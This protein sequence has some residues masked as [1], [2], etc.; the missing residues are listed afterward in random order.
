MRPE[1]PAE[2]VVEK[3]V[4][5]VYPVQSGADDNAEKGTAAPKPRN[6]IAKNADEVS[7]HN[8]ADFAGTERKN[9][10]K[11]EP[12]IKPA[13]PEETENASAGG[14]D[15]AQQN[16]STASAG[17]AFSAQDYVPNTYVSDS[18]FEEF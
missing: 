17:M 16:G 10:I 1:K 3:P 12:V 6:V 13:A 11:L 18:D 15:T 5:H 9:V 4:R 7:P 2:P 8:S 14:A